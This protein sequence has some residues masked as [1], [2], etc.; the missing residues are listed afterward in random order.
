MIAVRARAVGRAVAAVIVVAATFGVPAT[1]A[2]QPRLEV[3]FSGARWDGYDLDG[4]RAAITG[5]QTPTGSP[6][7]LFETDATIQPGPGAELRLGWRVFRGIYAEATGAVGVNAIETRVSG[8][9]EQAPPITLSSTLAQIT[10]E[11]GALVEVASLRALGGNL[12]P[13]V[14]GGGGYLRQVHDDRILVETGRT[15]YAGGGV[16]WRSTA[17]KPRGLG[18]RLVLRADARFVSRTGGVDVTDARRNYITV[19][20]GVGLRLF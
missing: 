11:G 14:D 4:G 10:I 15:M 5:P 6:V 12:V 7:T 18:Q 16:K 9:I 1:S 17:D 20:G 13:F 19:S 3:T 2:A 8:D